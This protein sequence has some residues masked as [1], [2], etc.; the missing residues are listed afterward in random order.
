[1]CC[2]IVKVFSFTSKIDK[3]L[4]LGEIQKGKW[5][6]YLR[7]QVLRKALKIREPLPLVSGEVP[8]FHGGSL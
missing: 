7:A 3:K 6:Y 5:L 2:K 8:R 4:S 1:M